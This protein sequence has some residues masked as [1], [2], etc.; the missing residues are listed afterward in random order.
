[1]INMNEN[2]RKIIKAL[3]K[4]GVDTRYVSLYDNSIYINNLK[5]SKFSRKKEEDF[6][7]LYPNISVVRSKLFQ[8]ICVKVSRTIK[9][10]I[11]PRDII[12]IED[13]NT[14]D[15]IL[16]NVVLESYRRKYGITIT[17]DRTQANKIVSTKCINDFASDYINLMISGDKITSYFNE[18]TI[19]PLLHIDYAWILDWI[20]TTNIRYKSKEKT[21]NET[22]DKIIKFLDTKIPNV[23]ES[24]IQSVKYLDEN[25]INN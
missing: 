17:T 10:Q 15:V 19:Y 7:S 1:M 24:I 22:S 20:D 14:P 6:G 13:D 25:T 12:Y 21:Q 18:N 11:K 3:N 16:L 2:E 5:F 8:K 4:I 9:N 23:S